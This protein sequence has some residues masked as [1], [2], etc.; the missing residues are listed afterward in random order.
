LSSA[1]S[2]FLRF[3]LRLLRFSPLLPSAFSAFLRF[4]LRLRA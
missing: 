1:F 2:A 3:V 4:V